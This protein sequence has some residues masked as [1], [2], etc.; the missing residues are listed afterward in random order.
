MNT[1]E[2][3]P[4]DSKPDA[5]D[6]PIRAPDAS[7]TA[8]ESADVSAALPKAALDADGK[9][10]RPLERTLRGERAGAPE[11]QDSSVAPSDEAGQPQSNGHS[12]EDLDGEAASDEEALGEDAG[13][14]SPPAHAGESGPEG[15]AAQG[16][17]K[18]RRRRRKKKPGVV[19]AAEGTAPETGEVQ[20]APEAPEGVVHD[21][22]VEPT[23][24][25]KRERKPGPSRERPPVNAGDIVFGKILEITDEA[26]LVDIP[27][28]ARAIFD[29]RE[30]LL[31]DDEDAG[32]TAPRR[33]PVQANHSGAVS[34]QSEPHLHP[35]LADGASEAEA[36]PSERTVPPV[37]ADS[38]ATV[39]PN[40]AATAVP[41]SEPAALH[42]DT[43]DDEGAATGP[44]PSTGEDSP[45]ALAVGT[46]VELAEPASMEAQRVEPAREPKVP[47]VI[48]EVGA[49]F[50]AVVHNDGA[51]GGLVV[52]THH[53][54]R[55]EKAKPAIEKAFNER[56]PLG[57]LVTGVIKGGIEVDVDGVRAFAPGS[58]VDLRLGA[59]LSHLVGKRLSFLVTQYAKRGRDVVLSRRS[60]LEE[61]AR[62]AR[63]EALAKLKVGDELDGIV[64]S[65]VPFGAFVDVG[66]IEGLVPLKEMSHN[67]A[68]GPS[69]V[70]TAGEAT[71]VRVVMIDDKGKVWLSH[72]ATIPD[73]WQQVAKRYAV[74]TRHS[75]KVV[76]L[77]PFGA[78]VELE[79]GVDGLIHTQDLSI[80]RIET[81]E[82]AVKTGDLLDVVVS[83]V[84][85]SQ[86]KI[87]LHPA[88]QGEAAGEASQ[89]VV[90][91]KAV[92]AKVVNIESG[93]LVVR[94]LGVT[95]RNARGYVTAAGT[96]TPRGTELRKVF[97][98]GQELEAKVIEMDPRRG[99]VKLSIK[100]LSEDQERN[101]YQQ[102]R[103]QLKAEARF[104][105]GDLLAKKGTP[106]R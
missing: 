11:K 48:L 31:P 57:G 72:K 106:P 67:R 55:A 97:N 82:E 8:A 32:Q 25:R 10:E 30:M 77:Q 47:R 86:H 6:A 61:E 88:P 58:H 74:G 15:S 69:D 33:P 2:T 65:V 90:P 94:I 96:G 66:G 50:I 52:L 92:K 79:P 104:T 95:G 17:K 44:G 63:T 7:H 45:E 46:A 29:R 18:R 42:P 85:A 75:G 20:A 78:F 102:Y 36:P 38:S 89:R 35:V 93:G 12:G 39:A 34:A 49:D 81:P 13:Q 40:Q 62:R 64:R 99:E 100:A 37:E 3:P 21:R 101:A 9:G 14:S 70:F 41:R 5:P 24:K 91:H 80:K 28:K 26:I 4:Q 73:P 71:R 87:A 103:Q 83:H 53:P 54:S 1:P 68:D 84:D 76:R 56:A 43:R 19:T 51:R 60:Q 27:G 16:E 59:D 22:V 23:P 105:F 98:V